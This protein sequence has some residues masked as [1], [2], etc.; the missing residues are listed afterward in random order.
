MGYNSIAKF[1]AEH[2]VFRSCAGS[3]RMTNLSTSGTHNHRLLQGLRVVASFFCIL[4]S[5][6]SRAW[7]FEGAGTE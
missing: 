3:F 5:M 1:S 7:R 2:Y 6:L 4:L